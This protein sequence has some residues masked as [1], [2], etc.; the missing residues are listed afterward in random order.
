MNRETE[1]D[2]LAGDTQRILADTVVTVRS[3]RPAAAYDPITRK[4]AVDLDAPE[5][6]GI[7]AVVDDDEPNQNGDKHTRRR[8][9]IVAA[10]D[11]GF[12]PSRGATVE[13]NGETWRVVSVQ[14]MTDRRDWRLVGERIE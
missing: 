4:R 1:L 2:M 11:L 10:A 6:V 14:R 8:A 12:N 13:E 3:L 7:P 5:A 9:W